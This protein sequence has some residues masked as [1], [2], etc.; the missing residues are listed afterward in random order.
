MTEYRTRALATPELG[1]GG[2]KECLLRVNRVV[3]GS[4][5]SL[6]DFR[7]ALKADISSIAHG[8]FLL[9][10]TEE[11]DHARR[12]QFRAAGTQADTLE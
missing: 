4:C 8:K 12:C 6:A 9:P 1:I 11:Y 7:N 2:C 10:V 5:R 3:A